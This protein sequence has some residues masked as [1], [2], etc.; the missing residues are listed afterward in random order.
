MTSK[1]G[2]K[3][4][5]TRQRILKV[6]TQEFAAKGYDGARIEVIMRRSKV[7]K[8]L[9]YHYFKSKEN[10][11]LEVLESDYEKM[12]RDHESWPNKTLG[13]ED[14][15]RALVQLVFRHWRTSN[16]FIR[17][18]ASENFS[19]GIHIRKLVGLR[20]GY[21]RWIEKITDVLN[22]GVRQGAFHPDVDP[23]ELYISISALVYHRIANR[24]TLAFLLD[25]DY[26]RQENLEACQA[27][28]ERMI[29]ADITLKGDGSGE[30]VGRTAKA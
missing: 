6:A 14:N 5:A 25:R 3:H 22:E 24:Y 23:T 2:E 16:H 20:E 11:F 26:D 17:L 30:A 4:P 8:N 28:I 29:L 7:S 18:L 27:H 10:L 9:I 13:P 1:S 12:Q 15:I 21:R 19:K